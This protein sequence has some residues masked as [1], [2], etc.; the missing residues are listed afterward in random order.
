M[1]KQLETHRNY[2]HS[3]PEISLEEHN[4]VKYIREVLTNIGVEYKEIGTSTVAFIA[5][6]SEECIAFR[7]DIDALPVV[8]ESGN[9]YRSKNIGMMH[10]C[11]HDGHTATLLTF[12][13]N[14]KQM[15]T[16]GTKLK[17]SLLFIFQAGEEGAG[18]ARFVVKDS[19]YKSKKIESIFALHVYP[20]LNTGGIA[21]K[22]GVLSLQNININITLTGKGCHGAQPHKGVDS[23]LIGAKLVEAYQSIASRNINPNSVFIFTIGSFKAGKV[24]NVIPEK[25]EI[26]G[27]I[28]IEDVSLIPFIKERITKINAGFEVSYD[29]KI[30]MEFMP[31][32]P[33]VINNSTLAEMAKKV[34]KNLEIE[35]EISLSGSEDFSFYLQ[36]GTPGLLCLLGIRDEEK[37]HIYPLHNSKFD[38]E[39]SVLKNGVEFFNSILAE[40]AL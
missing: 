8:E 37:D 28:R 25:V 38:F 29:V 34:V 35:T 40:T 15:I 6:E 7:A 24:R 11:G 14:T 2:L 20:E 23:I 30:D 32:Y 27:T 36:D 9:K 10:A 21:I 4:T 5:G 31:F 33:P 22:S 3:I 26:L 13:E 16:N 1:L 39:T 19:F 12:I 17:K 18:G